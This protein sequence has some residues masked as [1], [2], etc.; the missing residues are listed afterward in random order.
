M[1]SDS[2]KQDV[3]A[4]VSA[5]RLDPSLKAYLAPLLEP[6]ATGTVTDRDRL[7]GKNVTLSAPSASGYNLSYQWKKMA[8]RFPEQ[9]VKI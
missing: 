5:S 9:P 7:E 8:T 2:V 3:T 1:L 4:P 6:K